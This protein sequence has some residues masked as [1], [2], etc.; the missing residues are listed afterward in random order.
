M[1]LRGSRVRL[2]SAPPLHFSRR[3]CVFFV[4][5]LQSGAAGRYYT[6]STKDVGH[7]LEQHNDGMM[8]ATRP[9]RPWRLV[10]TEA[11]ETLVDARRREREI[12]S[13]K[14]RGRMQAQLGL[15]A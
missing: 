4:Y 3:I 14:S 9:Y 8:K 5:V 7:R 13:W 11:F 6:G 1:A 12:K 15:P 2:P 10:H